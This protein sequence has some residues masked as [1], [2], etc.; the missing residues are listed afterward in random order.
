[1]GV[2]RLVFLLL[3]TVIT[4][5]CEHAIEGADSD[6]EVSLL[7][8][9][10]GSPDPGFERAITAR[11]FVFPE[12]HGPHPGFATEW[13]YFTGNLFDDQGRRFGYQLTLFRIGLNPGQPA[14]DSDWR[15]HEMFMGHLAVSDVAA[16][17]HH[18][19]ERFSR[20]SAGLAGAQADPLHVWLGPWSIEGTSGD[21]FPLRINA[22]TDTFALELTIAEGQKRRVLQG[23]RGLS[24]KSDALGNA[25]YYYSHTRL[26][27]EGTVVIGNTSFAVSG[28]SWFDREW[29]SSALADDQAGWDWFA[30][31]L[32][33][34][35]DVMF[36]RMRGTDGEAQPF[37]K[38]VL[39]GHDGT[40]Q[41]L[42][43]DDVVLTP[44]RDW[45]APDGR[46]YPVAWTL[47]IPMHDLDLEIE[48]SFDDQQ[49]QT[50]VRYWEG[51]VDVLGSHT[52]VGYLEMSGYSV[53]M[54]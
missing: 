51:T 21:T 27:T 33:D 23:D 15:T 52:G 44:T 25:S 19:A 54:D 50:A 2:I 43:L 46:R 47:S 45:S 20:A 4:A 12:D 18:Q 17:R 53:S 8:G 32:D 49:M 13:W 26:P 9:M 11:E 1:M 42:R 37:S 7:D 6:T 10:G 5:A 30:L 22:V 14:Q 35:R 29:S 3:A 48:A 36:Y 41:P 24:Q 40:A 16:K 31:Q 34:G 28:N 38:G 39:V